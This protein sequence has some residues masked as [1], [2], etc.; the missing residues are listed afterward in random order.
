VLKKIGRG[1]EAAKAEFPSAATHD[2][3]I[4][5]DKG[6][7][8]RTAGHLGTSTADTTVNVYMQEVEEGVKQA[9]DAIY[10]ELT[11]TPGG[12]EGG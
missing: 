12:A 5:P 4:G 8:K 9:L 10:A 6:R 7:G 2:G 11:A 3:D 1:V